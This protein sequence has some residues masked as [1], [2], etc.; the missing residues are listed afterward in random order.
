MVHVPIL[1]SRAS[2]R[3]GLRALTVLVLMLA[4]VV[5]QGVSTE[6]IARPQTLYHERPVAAGPV[7]PGFPIDHVG[8]V[9]QLP[10]GTDAGHDHDGDVHAGAEGVAVRFRTQGQW[11]P[12]QQMIEDGAQ[13][14]GQWTGALVP[15]G[16]AEAYQV[17]GIPAFARGARA[18]ALNTTDGPLEVVG[19]RP[20]GAADAV[21]RCMSRRD[22]GADES[23]R[24]SDRSYAPVQ[25]VT[26]HHT[27]TQNDDPEPT[28]RVRA[29]YKYHVKTNR[30]DDIGYQALISEDGTVYEGRWSGSDSPSCASG[31]TGWE[32]GHL[33]T[34][35]GAPMVTGAHTGGYNT[36]NFGVALLG[37]LSD[38]APKAAARDALVKYLAELA[39]RHG[40]DPTSQVDYDNGTNSATADAISGHRDFSATLCPGGVLYDDL[41]QVRT[42]V[43]AAMFADPPTAGPPSAPTSLTATATSTT[44][45]DLAWPDVGDESG[46]HLERGT[47]SNGDGTTDT[48]GRIA[49]PGANVTA[50]SDSGLTGSTPYGYRVRAYSAA[51]ASDWI[52][53]AVTTH[54]VAD[55]GI[56][57]KTT[58]TKVKGEHHV[59]LE[60]SGATRVRIYRGDVAIATVA[61]SSYTD[62]TGRKGNGSY[63]HRV[64]AVDE[65]DVETGICSDPVVTTFS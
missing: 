5:V 23:L 48:W 27:A 52:N 8:V 16:D 63:E 28:A 30:W 14:V 62:A 45:V 43:A 38:V 29:I 10:A 49:E 4:S 46:Y 24:T 11:G 61:G 36:G 26:V 59:L 18:A 34:D 47:D 50:H 17:R 58:G 44:T 6:A 13:A 64:C 32:F 7:E 54:S 56:T 9:F 35:A 31:G 41:P 51:G 21:S 20:R 33:G 2:S 12:W 15:G 42:D 40:I 3:R 19:H 65:L 22:W 25:M 55:N 37:T 53:A 1:C 60:W 39:D 57:L